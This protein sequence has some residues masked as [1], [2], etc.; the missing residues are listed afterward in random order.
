M[1]FLENGFASKILQF[2]SVSI[3]PRRNCTKYLF[4]APWIID[5]SVICIS[6]FEEVGICNGD[7][8]G[9][10]VC[11]E[12]TSNGTIRKVLAGLTS[13]GSALCIGSP[14]VFTGVAAH[15]DYIFDILASHSGIDPL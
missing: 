14:G 13:W 7:S 6:Q 15:L 12:V 10:L 2:A 11:D 5:D 1:Q 3:Y 9:P 4:R 8:G